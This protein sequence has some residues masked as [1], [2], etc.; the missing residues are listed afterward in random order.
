[1][2]TRLTI[3]TVTPSS[4]RVV[5]RTL[6]AILPHFPGIDSCVARVTFYGAGIGQPRDGYDE[7]SYRHAAWHLGHAEVDALCWNG[8][9]GAGLGLAADRA[10][11]G[12]LAAA[13]GC[14]ATTTS[15]AAA[16]LLDALGVRRIGL[17][18][19]GLPGDAE[20]A[21]AGLGRRLVAARSL[22]L[23]TNQEA[24]RVPT[25]RIMELARAAAVEG[26]PEAILIWSTNLFGF[27]AMA[28]MEAELGIPVIDSAS[29]GVWACL[30]AIG[31]A[32]GPAGS[33]GRIFSVAGAGE[34]IVARA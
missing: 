16:A 26:R 5:E 30:A 17:I 7:D 18:T 34:V 9:R 10:L 31:A 25:T 33:L 19:P 14:P 6:A 21:A 24:A 3:G 28:P 22:G 27:E 2:T 15:L 11:A 13:A 4:N 1:M 29:V 32:L 8:T 23:K 20:Q 12:T